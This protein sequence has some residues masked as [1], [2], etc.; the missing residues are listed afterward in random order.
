[1]K[2]SE[3]KNLLSA[4]WDN[5]L[6]VEMRNSVD[7][8]I[9]ECLECKTELEN[10]KSLSSLTAGLDQPETPASVWTAVER[11]LGEKEPVFRE[12][13]TPAEPTQ[14]ELRPPNRGIRSTGRTRAFFQ[15]AAAIAATLLVGF[16]GMKQWMHGDH[17][18]MVKAME[19]V[20]SEINLDSSTNLLLKKFGGSEV[21]YRQAITQVGY[22]PVASK[23]LSTN[24][25]LNSK[26][27][28]A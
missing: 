9:G 5:E 3:T 16:V 21:T 15:I 4:Y 7:A 23:G 11:G 14:R 12:G 25:K 28:R 6:S 17:A 10:F 13:E 26:I 27:S 8:H 20:A 22:R 19:Q 1:M 18:E 24:A 2:C